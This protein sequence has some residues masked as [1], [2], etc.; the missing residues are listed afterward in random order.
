MHIQQYLFAIC[1]IAIAEIANGI[2]YYISNAGIDGNTCGTLSQPCGTMYKLSIIINPLPYNDTTNI[3]ISGQNEQQLNEYISDVNFR[4]QHHPCLFNT[5]DIV[6]N[7]PQTK[8]NSSIN[9]IFD[10]Q[11]TTMSDWYPDICTNIAITSSFPDWQT[12]MFVVGPWALEYI[13]IN[14]HNLIID[15]FI[16]DN[17]GLLYSESMY[18]NFYNCTFRTITILNMQYLISISYGSF[19]NCTFDSINMSDGECF[20]KVVFHGISIQPVVIDHISMQNIRVPI[21]LKGSS[22]FDIKNSYLN[23]IYTELM[24]F[25]TFDSFDEINIQN[26]RILNIKHGGIL[27]IRATINSADYSTKSQISLS[28]LDISVVSSEFTDYLFQ[29]IF[30]KQKIDGLSNFST[31]FERITITYQ[32][33]LYKRCNVAYGYIDGKYLTVNHTTKEFERYSFKNILGMSC[34]NPTPFIHSYKSNKL[35]VSNMNVSIDFMDENDQIIT[36]DDFRESLAKQFNFAAD[37]LNK[38]TSI[39]SFEFNIYSSNQQLYIKY[40]DQ[41]FIFSEKDDDVTISD[42]SFQFYTLFEILIQIYGVYTVEINKFMVTSIQGNVYNPNDLKSKYVIWTEDCNNAHIIN[43][44]I[45]HAVYLFRPYYNTNNLYIENSTLHHA[46]SSLNGYLYYKYAPNLN[47]SFN[48]CLFY[49]LGNY[50]SSFDLMGETTYLMEQSPMWI[51]GAT[52]RIINCT[53]TFYSV[54]GFMHF[55]DPKSVFLE[56]NIFIFS[57]ENYDIWYRSYL[58]RSFYLCG[59]IKFLGYNSTVELIGNYFGKNEVDPSIPILCIGRVNYFYLKNT[60]PPIHTCLTGNIIFNYAMYLDSVYLSSCFRPQLYQIMTQ[61]TFNECSHIS[62]GPLRSDLA[63]EIGTFM[64]DTH[65]ENYIINAVSSPVSHTIIALDNTHFN[66]SNET[67]WRPYPIT[68]MYGANRFLMIDSLINKNADFLYNL[69]DCNTICNQLYNG[70]ECYDNNCISDKNLQISQV[71]VIC[72][73]PSSMGYGE[74]DYFIRSNNKSYSN[75]LSPIK[76]QLLGLMQYYAG[77]LL[78]MTYRISDKHN[79]TVSK[80]SLNSTFKLELRNDDLNFYDALVIS[81][82]NDC[83]LC[84]QGIYIPTIVIDEVNSSYDIRVS[85][86][87][88]QLQTSNVTIT[89]VDCPNGFGTNQIE[90]QC[91]QCSDGH[92]GFHGQCYGCNQYQNIGID[93][94]GGDEIIVDQYY[95][96]N[97]ENTHNSVS[98]ISGVCPD[99]YCCMQQNGCHFFNNKTLLCAPNRDANSILCGKCVDGYSELLFTASCGRCENN[100][101]IWL[102]YPFLMAFGITYYLLLSDAISVKQKNQRSSCKCCKGDCTK[103]FGCC[104]MKFVKLARC[105]QNRMIKHQTSV[106][107]VKITFLHC[108]T[109]YQQAISHILLPTNINLNLVS[110]SEMFNLSIYTNSN[111]SY[112]GYCFIKGMTAKGEILTGFIVIFMMIFLLIFLFI[113]YGYIYQ[114]SSLLCNRSPLFSKT[115]IAILLLSIGKVLTIMFKLLACQS[116]DDTLYHLYFGNDECFDFIWWFAL[117]SIWI[118]VLIFALL[119][120]CLKNTNE[121]QRQSNE[122]ALRPLTVSYKSQFFYWEIIITIRRILIAGLSIGFGNNN[123]YSTLIL[124]A[125]LGIFVRLQAKYEPFV[126]QQA[127]AMESNLLICLMI[128]LS[129]SALN[130]QSNDDKFIYVVV[131]ISIIIPFIFMLWDIACIECV[132][133]KKNWSDNGDDSES[134]LQVNVKSTSKLDIAMRQSLLTL[135]NK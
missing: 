11:F 80:D 81:E 9:I 128:I 96:M 53:F 34:S 3:F 60:L 46:Y 125:I 39:I 82:E 104:K 14:F 135:S 103:F 113:V 88:N 40:K 50:F 22:H 77:D 92:F 70:S 97:I 78:R 37:E 2:N 23:N 45:S 42:L 134:Q 71:S 106:T 116:I 28:D 120:H 43:S 31:H 61:N 131:A 26:C 85:E 20:I 35:D 47:I 127:N 79:N 19:N 95:W 76:I 75:H 86:T 49:A 114:F 10:P 94:R 126:I 66:L 68:K 56:R 5:L 38:Q 72:D 16:F 100:H 111:D 55:E 121:H 15:N 107:M 133:V 29:I 54:T 48:S 73:S 41:N 1:F 130:N 6:E 118:I 84:Q 13:D 7:H 99:S 8:S 36:L 122:N 109:Y 59:L 108:I 64:I 112:K 32:Y 52:T 17:F 24:L 30:P 83:N 58:N 98:I 93:C 123:I 18:V 67:I 117:F 69:K 57:N 129:V 91:E 51:S 105:F 25:T 63:N 87:T 27:H 102:L 33:H 101:Y 90:T 62:Y 110:L 115:F 119:S 65:N 132:T 44:D 124:I 4:P 12:V 21:L 74:N 89:V